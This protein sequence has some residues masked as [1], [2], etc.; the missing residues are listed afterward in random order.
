MGLEIC[1]SV[2]GQTRPT[3]LYSGGGIAASDCSDL[4]DVAHQQ[5]LSVTMIMIRTIVTIMLIIIT[6]IIISIISIIIIT[7]NIFNTI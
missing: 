3:T 1:S 5:V 2:L 7:I 6:I 4:R